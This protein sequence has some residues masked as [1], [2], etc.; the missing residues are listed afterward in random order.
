MDRFRCVLRGRS[1]ATHQNVELHADHVKSVADGGKTMIENL[2]PTRQDCNLGKGRVAEKEFRQFKIG[3]R[4]IHDLLF[5][6]IRQF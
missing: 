6:R 1:P 4:G 2:Q 5:S 3:R